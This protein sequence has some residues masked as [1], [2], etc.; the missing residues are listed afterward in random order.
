M[1]QPVGLDQTLVFTANGA[2]LVWNPAV[3]FVGDRTLVVRAT[4]A[5]LNGC[6]VRIHPMLPQAQC[7]TASLV[8]VYAS[9]EW[10]TGGRGYLVTGPEEVMTMFASLDS[11]EDDPCPDGQI[12]TSTS[13][14]EE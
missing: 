14:G 9:M 2:G 1:R 8:G 4:T 10:A 6:Q 7:S 13:L 12:E 5:A 11:D 3:G